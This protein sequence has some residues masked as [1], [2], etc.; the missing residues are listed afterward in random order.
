[1]QIFLRRAG[2]DVTPPL[3]R[4]HPEIADPADHHPA[5][6]NCTELVASVPQILFTNMM[7]ATCILDTFWLHLC[8]ALHYGELAFDIAEGLMRPSQPLR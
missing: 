8:G 2:V 7:V 6:K 1:V 4:H 3:T 5:E